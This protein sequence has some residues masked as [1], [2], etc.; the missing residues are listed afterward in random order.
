MRVHKGQNDTNNQMILTQVC[1]TQISKHVLPPQ[2]K[3]IGREPSY[4]FP[5]GYQ[6]QVLSV[7]DSKC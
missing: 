3:A 7:S 6:A 2:T 4:N 1:G 5:I